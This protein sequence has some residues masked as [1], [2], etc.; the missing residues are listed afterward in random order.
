MALC[1]YVHDFFTQHYR[2]TIGVDFALKVIRLLENQLSTF[3]NSVLLHSFVLRQIHHPPETPPETPPPVKT[4]F[5]AAG[6]FILGMERV[7]D[8]FSLLYV[9]HG[10]KFQS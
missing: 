3:A 2:A 1:R 4:T 6:G 8:H 5:G 9:F 7:T 10:Y